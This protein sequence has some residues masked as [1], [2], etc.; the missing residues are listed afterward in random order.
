MAINLYLKNFRCYS[1]FSSSF[2]LGI[3]FIHGDNG[4]GKTSILEAISILS[5]GKGIRGCMIRDIKKLE[6]EP[7]QD[8]L[9]YVSIDVDNLRFSIELGQNLKKIK[10][11]E[12]NI[13][14]IEVLSELSILWLT[15]QIIFDFWAS[16]QS[17]RNFLDRMCMNYIPTHST[18]VIKYNNAR[19]KRRD[20]INKIGYDFFNQQEL[21]KCYH[22]LIVS[23]GIKIMTNR[24]KMIDIINSDIK[25]IHLEMQGKYEQMMMKLGSIT[26]PEECVSSIQNLWVKELSKNV[27]FAGPHNSDVF[28]YYN[29]IHHKYISTGQKSL[30][31][32]KILIHISTILRKQKIILLDDVLA[33]LDD[34]IRNIICD[35][36][37]SLIDVYII[38]TD[39]SSVN[40]NHRL[41]TT[42]MYL[43]N[44]NLHLTH[45]NA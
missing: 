44:H 42:Q 17:R 38:V 9:S 22:E 40:H 16:P 24:L 39:A 14:N 1:D 3:N 7:S 5:P 45:N 4:S 35:L 26:A 41:H 27:D 37:F 15:P 34:K 20:I 21:Y 23:H 19:N 2:N 12:V 6:T 36:L 8:T 28:I 29:H 18:E 10:R 43:K 32:T 30:V 31:L 25:D 13:R 11:N 33:H